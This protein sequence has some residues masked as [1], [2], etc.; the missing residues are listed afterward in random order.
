MIGVDQEDDVGL[1]NF[2]AQ[3]G[4]VLWAGGCIDDGGGNIFGCSGRRGNGDLGKDGLYL[5][6]DEDA[7]DQRGN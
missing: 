1:S 5:V 4:S 3:G 7:L 6:G 2:L